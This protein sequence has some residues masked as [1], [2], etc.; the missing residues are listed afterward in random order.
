[1]VLDTVRKILQALW[2][3]QVRYALV[4]GIALNLHG[5]SRNTLDI[6]LLIPEDPDNLDRLKQALDYV[7]QDPSIQEISAS[8]LA[9]YAVIRYGTPSDFYIDIILRLGEMF[10]FE[11]VET[12]QVLIEGCPVSLATPD[13]LIRMKSGTMRPQDAA[14][15]VCLREKY[16]LP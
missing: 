11:N 2:K 16:K 12:E 8:D 14:D 3:H 10:S 13:A 5:I 4:G 15:A 1:M 7:F 9:S 6:D